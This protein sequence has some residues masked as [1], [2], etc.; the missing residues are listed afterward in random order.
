MDEY[1]A[2]YSGLYPY[3]GPDTAKKP[4]FD[5][6]WSKD[7]R[8]KD[9]VTAVL[10][11]NTAGSYKLPIT[12][13]SKAAGPLC[14][15]PRSPPC[16]VYYFSQTNSWM[17]GP[18]MADW[19]TSVFVREVRRVTSEPVFLVMNNA[20]SHCKLE[21]DGVTVVCLPPNT[22]SLDQPRDMEIISAVKR[23]HKAR[24]LRR[25][26]RQLN[27]LLG[28]GSAA[29]GAPSRPGHSP[30]EPPTQPHP[31]PEPAAPGPSPAPLAP[32][33]RLPHPPTAGP[34]AGSP[35][36]SPL[37]PSLRPLAATGA[38][39]SAPSTSSLT[40]QRPFIFLFPRV[41]PRPVAPLAPPCRGV[42][43]PVDGNSPPSAAAAVGET[44]LAPVSGI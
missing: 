25:R 6:P 3:S 17:D 34:P 41:A 16:P 39:P 33:S 13:I 18:T 27:S 15:Q 37:P 19:F 22:T 28:A 5:N 24:L 14:F 1:S 26:L 29:F 35:P 31:H 38:A 42:A 44:R 43:D 32:S 30:P 7:M 21:A 9:R 8:A 40:P 36:T 20:P 11:V 23:R 4:Y 2:T 12:V 10:C